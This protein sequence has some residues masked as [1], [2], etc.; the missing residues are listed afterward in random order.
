MGVRQKGPE[1]RATLP[2]CEV[3]IRPACGGN[4]AVGPGHLERSHVLL[5]LCR[6]VTRGLDVWKAKHELQEVGSGQGSLGRPAH[7]SPQ[8]G[9]TPVSTHQYQ[10]HFHLVEV[11]TLLRRSIGSRDLGHG[12]LV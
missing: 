6:K 1:N 5:W 12:E 2:R 11:L 8:T 4:V 9:Y 3:S 7:S 10:Y